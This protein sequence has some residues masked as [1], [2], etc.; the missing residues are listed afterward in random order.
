MKHTIMYVRTTEEPVFILDG[1]DLQ[2]Q[3]HVRRP[4]QSREGIQHVNETFF[5]AEL[6]TR[7]ERKKRLIAERKELDAMMK[8]AMAD[9]EAED[10]QP[11]IPN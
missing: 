9:D 7:D 4:V 8:A 10:A 3:V 6:E 5:V 1:P 11:L 2:Q